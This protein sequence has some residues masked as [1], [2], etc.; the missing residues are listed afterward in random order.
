[1][2]IVG[3]IYKGRTLNSFKGEEVRPTADKVRESLFNILQFNI[4]DRVFLDLFCGTG[5]VGIEALSRGAKRVVFND[6][7]K[8][9]V[10][11]TKCNLKKLGITESVQVFNQNAL[12]YLKNSTEKFDIIFIDPPYKENL[13]FKVLELAKDLLTNDGLVIIED[14]KPF[15]EEIE[16]LEI[17]DRRKYGRVHLTFFKR[18]QND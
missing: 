5:A 2:R 1:M 3:G 13:Y 9:S 18:K 7:S 14:E 4:Q 6:L 15:N 8:E 12:T 16:T 17:I 10:L 11:L